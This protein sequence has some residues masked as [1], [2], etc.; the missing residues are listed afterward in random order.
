LEEEIS[1]FFR[2]LSSTGSLACVSLD[3]LPEILQTQKT[4]HESDLVQRRFQEESAE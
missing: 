4:G 3:A 2:K 1:G